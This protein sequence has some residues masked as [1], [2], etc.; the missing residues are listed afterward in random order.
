VRLIE[1]SD[2]SIIWSRQF[3]QSASAGIFE[4]QRTATMIAS[5]VHSYLAASRTFT[6]HDTFRHLSLLVALCAAPRYWPRCA[7]A[8]RRL[9]GKTKPE[10]E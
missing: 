10:G 8:Q 5:E 9:G 2:V 3:D 7:F 4:Q 1:A 6:L